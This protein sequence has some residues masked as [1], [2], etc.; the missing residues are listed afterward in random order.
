M[1]YYYY[2]YLYQ[3][4]YV[5]ISISLFCLFVHVLAGL[6][7][8]YSTD[9]FIQNQGKMAHGPRKKPLDFCGNLDHITPR[10]GFG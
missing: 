7:Q 3:Q 10:E 9:F 1:L 5:F 4:G 6:H 2:Y 8:N